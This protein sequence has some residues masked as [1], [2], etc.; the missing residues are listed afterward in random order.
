[1][2]PPPGFVNVADDRQED[3]GYFS[4][5]NDDVDVQDSQMF[6]RRLMFALRIHRHMPMIYCSVLCAGCTIVGPVLPEH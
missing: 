6:I 2:V 1:M 5:E 4:V 3:G